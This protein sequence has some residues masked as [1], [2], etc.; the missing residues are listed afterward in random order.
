MVFG[1]G[2][3]LVIV[4]VLAICRVEEGTQRGLGERTWNEKRKKNQ[5]KVENKQTQK[6][7]KRTNNKTKLKLSRIPL[8][9]KDL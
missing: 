5:R 4:L 7:T 6:Q 3:E 2:W 1:F 9:K 8:N